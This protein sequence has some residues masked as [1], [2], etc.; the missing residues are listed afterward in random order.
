MTDRNNFQKMTLFSFVAL[1]AMSGF[2][3]T[4]G[5]RTS[6]P[7]TVRFPRGGAV[8]SLSLPDKTHPYVQSLLTEAA[9][10]LKMHLDLITGQSVPV[11]TNL[12]SDSSRYVFW[13]NAAPMNDKDVLACE[14]ARW[15]VTP[16]GAWLYGGNPAG[17][18]YAVTDFLEEGLG[19]RWPW[20]TNIAF[21]AMNPLVV[22]KAEG[23]FVPAVPFHHIRKPKGMVKRPVWLARLRDGGWESPNYGHAFVGWGARFAATHP[24][25]VAMRAD[26]KRLPTGFPADKTIVEAAATKH[27][28]GMPL[29]DRMSMCFTAPGLAE[30]LVEDWKRKGAREWINTCDNDVGGAELCHCP[31]CTALDE[32]KPADELP[33]RVTHLSD[34]AVWFAKKCLALA[35]PINP[36]VRATIYAYNGTERAPQREKVENGDVV[37]V[38][39][40]TKCSMPAVKRLYGGWTAM[41]FKNFGVRP[42]HHGYY[43]STALPMGCE[44]L[45]FDKWQY[46]YSIG[47]RWF[48]YDA[49]NREYPQEYV[50]D[51]VLMKAMQDPSKPF[52]YWMDHYCQAFG[53]AKG[54]VKDYYRYWREDVWDK[55]IM[56][57]LEELEKPYYVIRPLY[58]HL[59]KYYS[60]KDFDET[61]AILARALGRPGLLRADRERVKE[62]AFCNRHGRL[63][64][65]AVTKKTDTASAALARFRKDHGL[66]TVFWDE[67]YIHDITGVKTYLYKTNPKDVPI[68]FRNRDRKKGIFVPF[69]EDDIPGTGVEALKK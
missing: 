52:E 8:V 36:K 33:N 57:N 18:G 30:Q 61:D 66:P 44:K 59:G 3:G 17:V 29:T 58:D 23:R 35:R 64:F 48:D 68:Y 38:I 42:N 49:G 40:P 5:G 14:E 21:R 10:E 69:A 43:R 22:S 60:A 56:P 45:M 51:Y 55:R 26:G 2:C 15:R 27:R 11:V 53:A 34:R 37:A 32:P 7:V 9:Q 25:W 6:A 50:K 4:N 20:G 1:A 13:V 54:D 16:R 12:Q 63:F 28:S 46:E 31:N 19:V 67:W 41:G 39:V 47:A 62:L 24:E 65:E